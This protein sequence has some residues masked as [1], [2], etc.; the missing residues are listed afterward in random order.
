MNEKTLRRIANTLVA[1]ADL[2]ER[3]SLRS[4]PVLCLVLWLLRPAERIAREFAVDALR[5]RPDEMPAVVETE[6]READARAEALRLAFA[7]RL[8]ALLIAG[9]AAQCA[10]LPF[11]VIPRFAISARCCGAPLPQPAYADTS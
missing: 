5:L 10:A 2:A 1:L 8:L 3:A 9:V 6:V 11:C 7:L 4:Y